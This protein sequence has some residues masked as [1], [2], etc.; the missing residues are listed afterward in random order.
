MVAVQQA[1]A[2]RS[3]SSTVVVAILN[4]SVGTVT[5]HHIEEYSAATKVLDPKNGCGSCR[6][7]TVATFESD[8]CAE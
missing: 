7:H 4:I 5:S 2:V 8:L 1:I 6:V 3:C